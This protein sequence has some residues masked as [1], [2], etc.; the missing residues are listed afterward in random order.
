MR[1]TQSVTNGRISQ[2]LLAPPPHTH[3][4]QPQAQATTDGIMKWIN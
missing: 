3:T 4:R 2:K 1:L